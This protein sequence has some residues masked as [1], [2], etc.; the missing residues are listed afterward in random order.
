MHRVIFGA[1]CPSKSGLMNKHIVKKHIVMQPLDLL[2]SVCNNAS[3]TDAERSFLTRNQIMS[4]R[5]YRYLLICRDDLRAVI[6]CQIHEDFVVE[7]IVTPLRVIL[8]KT[9]QTNQKQ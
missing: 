1:L 8:M 2:T 3:L 7:S 5:R 6:S 4:Y 9:N